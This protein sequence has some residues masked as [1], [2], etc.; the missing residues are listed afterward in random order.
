MNAHLCLDTKFN[1]TITMWT[2]R[3]YKTIYLRGLLFLH[4]QVVNRIYVT[5]V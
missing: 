3:S 1:S 4:T 2:F 5:A